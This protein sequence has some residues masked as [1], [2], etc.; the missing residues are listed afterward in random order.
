MPVITREIRND[1]A[2]VRASVTPAGRSVRDGSPVSADIVRGALPAALDTGSDICGLSGNVA[3]SVG[4]FPFRTDSVK[5]A[6]GDSFR[7]FY[8]VDVH[9]W[10]GNNIVTCHRKLAAEI[11]GTPVPLLIGMNVIRIGS[12]HVAAN[13]FTFAL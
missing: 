11:K 7:N 1:M 3:K 5:T 9:I 6:D 10:M 13:S 8:E 2:I 4:A 12:L